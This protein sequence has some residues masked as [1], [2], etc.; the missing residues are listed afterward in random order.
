MDVPD[1]VLSPDALYGPLGRIVSA[2]APHTEANP[3]AILAALLVY[4]SAIAGEGSSLYQGGDQ[5]AKL[6]AAIVGPTSLARKGTALDLA[7]EVMNLAVPGAVQAL[8]ISGAASGEGLVR[9]LRYRTQSGEGWTADPR[10]LVNEPEFSRFLRAMSWRGST[11]SANFCKAWDG[12][13]LEHTTVR[14]TLRASGHHLCAIV[15]ITREVLR[16]EL[17]D[18]DA[19][20]GFSNRF[21]WVWSPVGNVTHAF[22]TP[23]EQLVATSDIDALR[24]AIEWGRERIEVYRSLDPLTRGKHAA[25]WQWSPEA[26]ALWE[27]QYRKRSDQYGMRAALT[28]RADPLVARLAVVYAITDQRPGDAPPWFIRP[29]HLR[30]AEAFWSYC[31]ESVTSIFGDSTGNRHA[32]V[33]LDLLRQSPVHRIDWIDLPRALGLRTAADLNETVAVLTQIGVARIVQEER[34][35]GG[36]PKR[37]VALA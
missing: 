16:K 3:A 33:L 13:T 5:A 21:L 2:L 22:T 20:S 24:G 6:F 25:A 19:Q 8:S 29:E 28:A 1:P 14:E 26:A 32:D 17:T 4:F 18:E 7:E 35:T 12:K 23:A 30:A 10:A 11:L 27:E 36:R 37:A 34:P 15:A 9:D 31:R